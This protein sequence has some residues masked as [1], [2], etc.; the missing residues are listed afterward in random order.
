[1]IDSTIRT[2][3]ASA[4]TPSAITYLD[5]LLH[6]A[7]TLRA[8]DIHLEPAPESYQ[9]RFRIDGLL[10]LMNSVEQT[11]GFQ[12]IS[13]IKVLASLNGAER[14][15]PQDGKLSVTFFN[16]PFDVRISTFPGVYGEK[17]VLRILERSGAQHELSQLGFEPEMYTRIQ[18]IA[19]TSA[20]FFLVTGP[21]GSGKTTTLHAL[22]SFLKRPEINITT[23][24]DPVEYVID[25]ITQ[26]QINPDIGFTFEKGIRSLLRADPD[27]IMVGEIRDRETAHV[28]LQA[29]MTGHFVVSTL[30]TTDA[31]SAL[32]RLLEMRV[33]PFLVQAAVTA[34]LAQRLVRKLCSE[35]RF[36]TSPT[37]EEKECMKRFG[38]EAQSLY[39]SDGCAECFNTGYKGRIGIF[40]LLVMSHSLRA[41]LTH[42]TDYLSL[43]AQAVREGMASLSADGALKIRAG[44][45]SLSELVRVVL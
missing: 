5:E 42:Q 20:G 37:E 10:C 30:H 14:R 34:I 19:Q 27:V 1:M 29:A 32:L 45:T 18:Q 6:Q 13:R 12:T 15:I 28:S 8:S 3:K 31:P 9:V 22:L 2:G 40:Q 43:H 41:L 44:I 23:L 35:C 21:T 17:L 38:I 4:H 33:E 24:E 36:E 11:L 25:G 26:T 39:K 7:I 16:K